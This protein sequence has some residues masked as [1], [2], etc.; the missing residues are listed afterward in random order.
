MEICLI[1]RE[2]SGTGA[3]LYNENEVITKYEIMD[4]CPVKGQCVPIRFF[5][6]AFPLTPSFK[7]EHNKFSVKV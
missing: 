3:N 1:R 2:S 7:S 5:L 4:G 6:G